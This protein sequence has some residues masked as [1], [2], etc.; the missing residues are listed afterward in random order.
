M[1]TTT[2]LI[3]LQNNIISF[4]NQFM[5]KKRVD[6]MGLIKTYLEKD[7]NQSILLLNLK[8]EYSNLTKAYE[9]ILQ[10]FSYKKKKDILKAR[11]EIEKDYPELANAALIGFNLLARMEVYTKRLLKIIKQEIKYVEKENKKEL[12]KVFNQK[13]ALQETI[14]RGNEKFYKNFN[15]SISKLKT[16]EKFLSLKDTLKQVIKSETGSTGP[17]FLFGLAG[18]V[19]FPILTY[20]Q[21]KHVGLSTVSSEFWLIGQMMGT[22]G[23]LGAVLSVVFFAIV[24]KQ[25]R[26]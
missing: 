19:G 11:K 20:A 23:L 25:A 1:T 8:S 15:A 4:H 9:L 14:G 24:I 12:R 22:N 16:N 5:K 3:S 13:I 26:K 6:I 7:K 10:T 2:E 21:M 17:W 18:S